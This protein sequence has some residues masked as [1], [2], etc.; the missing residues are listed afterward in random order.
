MVKAGEAPPLTI[1]S[2]EQI[3]LARAVNAADTTANVIYAAITNI[4]T[5]DLG[6]GSLNR[7]LYCPT[8]W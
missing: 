4:M 7:F 1:P 6:A 2:S 5:G 8:G 3:E